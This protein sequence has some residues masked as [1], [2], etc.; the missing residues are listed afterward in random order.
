MTLVMLFTIL[1]N[2]FN[3]LQIAIN[4]GYLDIVKIVLEDTRFTG[5]NTKTE[6]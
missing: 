1:Q 6:V 2:A 4:R 5:I 3:A